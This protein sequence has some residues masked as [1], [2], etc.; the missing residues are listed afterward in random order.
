MITVAP[1]RFAS[2]I[3]VSALRFV[4]RFTARPTIGG[5]SRASASE[6]SWIVRNVLS[7]TPTA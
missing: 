1:R 7:K 3:I 4:I 2:A 5:R 6:K